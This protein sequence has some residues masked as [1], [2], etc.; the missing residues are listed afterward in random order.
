MLYWQ[1]II[2]YTSYVIIVFVILHSPSWLYFTNRPTGKT[3]SWLNRKNK[4]AHDYTV[5]LTVRFE[6]QTNRLLHSLLWR[7]VLKCLIF[8]YK[9]SF[10]ICF[11]FR[12][13]DN[14][15]LLFFCFVFMIYRLWCYRF[16]YLKSRT[17]SDLLFI[18]VYYKIMFCTRAE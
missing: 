16:Y 7:S 18:I 2:F 15:Y 11:I 12:F 17:Q 8:I 6:S 14:K 1:Y 5:L 13:D 4:T 9:P 10:F 3:I